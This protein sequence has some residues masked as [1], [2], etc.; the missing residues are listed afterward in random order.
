MVRSRR[1]S[2]YFPLVRIAFVGTGYVAD[3]YLTTL[4][5]YPN[6]ILTGVWDHRPEAL[7]HFATAHHLRKYDSY[8]QLLA[9][10]VDIVVNL[11][12]PQSHY[13]VSKTALLAGKHV[14]T[15]KPLGMTMAEVDDLV[16]LA[17]RNNLQL[18]GAPCSLLGETAQTLWRE[19]RK[20]RMGRVRA[21]YANLDDGDMWQM[22]YAGW[23]STT[24]IPWPW[25]NE[26]ETGV[27]LEHAGYYLS[28]LPAFFGPA[29]HV[30][31]MSSTLVEDKRTSE[32]LDNNA[33]DFSLAVITFESGVIARVTCS[34]M[35]EH[36]HSL[37]I[38][39]DNGTLSTQDAWD[40]GSPIRFKKL[41]NI[42]R[43][44]QVLPAVPVKHV[45]KP[46]KY[47]YPGAQQMDFARGINEMVS[48]I[49]D[50]RANRLSAD[51]SRHV[52]ELVLAMHHAGA[53]GV[54]M[55]VT[56]RFDPIEPMDW[57]K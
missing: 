6:L 18:S 43:R 19:I 45:K 35:P 23:L 7:N 4:K 40:Y 24:G 42:R 29:T 47:D 21:V 55:P 49:K 46:E 26:F 39:G 52:N 15:E 54:S 13:D 22:P 14:Y 53:K 34:M 38:F 2:R 31:A 37:Q 5:G 8:E 36:D 56:S 1:Q 50:K 48:S 9:D 27:T 44:R 51:Y 16:E 28:W 41:V 10:D 17:K 11:T 25:K 30:T 3:Y 12:N 57:A 32:P 20:G 33:A